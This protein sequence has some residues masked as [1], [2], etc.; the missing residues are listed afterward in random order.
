MHAYLS[1]SGFSKLLTH[2]WAKQKSSYSSCSKDEDEPTIFKWSWL[3]EKEHLKQ[4]HNE[5]DS[6]SISS[7]LPSLIKGNSECCID[8]TNILNDMD[9]GMTYTKGGDTLDWTNW[10]NSQVTLNP[11]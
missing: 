2:R 8:T 5:M 11:Q 10:A 9:H 3:P 1:E 6:T 4:T 7:D